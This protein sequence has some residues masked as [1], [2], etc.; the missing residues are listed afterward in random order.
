MRG[1]FGT[2]AAPEQKATASTTYG[3]L[4]LWRDLFGGRPSATG[5]SVTWKKALEVTTVLRCATIWAEGICS[6]P[7]KLYQR[8]ERDGRVGRREA[9]EHPL[10]D[11]M[12]SGP[13]D[14]QTSFEFRETIGLHLALCGNA[15]VFVNRVKGDIVELIPFEPGNVTVEQKPNWDV[16]YRVTGIDGRQ[17]RFPAGAIWHLRRRSWNSYMGLE[18]IALAREAIGL[19]LATEESHGRMHNKAVRPSGV[20]SMDGTLNEAQFKSLRAWVTENYAGVANTGIPLIL[21]RAAK[22]QSQQMSGVDAQHLQTRGFQIEESCRALDILPIMVGYTGDKNATFASSEQMFLA[23]HVHTTRPAHRRVEQSGDKWLLSKE[24]RRRGYYTGFVDTE[25]LRGDHKARAE[26]YE[27]GIRA[28]WMLPEEPRA[29]EEMD[30]VAG[31]DRP[32]IPLNTTIVGEDGKPVPLPK[33]VPTD[34]VN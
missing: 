5:I 31:L 19:A 27:S 21:D 8:V 23:H 29:F 15:F 25:L 34:A 26:Y 14:W 2:I 30:Y 32:R 7:W 11:L 1:L 16:E 17:E 33:E 18:T 20:L 9:R 6:V 4:E 22:W 3:G 13:N 10:W 12:S 24:E 28:G